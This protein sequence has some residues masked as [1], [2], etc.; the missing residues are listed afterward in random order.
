MAS[1]F[2]NKCKITKSVSDFIKSSST[3]DGFRYECKTCNAEIVKQ[4]RENNRD[5]LNERERYR[6]AI[7]PQRRMSKSMH[8][9]LNKILRRG[10]YSLRTEAIIG[11]NMATFLEWL[12]YNFENEMTWA[13]YGSLWQFDL[14]I[15]ASAYDL[16]TE[17]GLL[18]CFNW[19][20]IRPCIK[21]DNAAKFNCIIP[22][23]Q[24]N[25]SIRVLGFI[26]KLRQLK[27]KAFLNKFK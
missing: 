25:Q 22:F 3:S 11:L 26:R 27:L 20:N 23:A 4:W 7:N 18:A 2:C 16:T 12:N 9:R 10:H 14:V 19:K 15:P 13:Y 8:N 5:H 24:A 6:V 17:E 1:K 21:A